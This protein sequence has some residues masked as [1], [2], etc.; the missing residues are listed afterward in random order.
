MTPLTIRG[1]PIPKNPTT[2]GGHL[3]RH[4]ARLRLHRSEASYSLGVSTVTLSRWECDKVFP[5]VQ[6]HR[7][8]IEYLGYDPFENGPPEAPTPPDATNP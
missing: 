3:R 2:I 6:F 8:I 4:R 7:Q 1:I 5:R